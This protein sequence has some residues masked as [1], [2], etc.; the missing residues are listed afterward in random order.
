[1]SLVRA[2]KP[3]GAVFVPWAAVSSIT[4]E[5]LPAAAAVVAYHG[6]GAEMDL[7]GAVEKRFSADL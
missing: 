5:M 3:V 7:T 4:M 1:M 2:T 6:V